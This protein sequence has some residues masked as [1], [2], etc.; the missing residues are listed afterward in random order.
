MSNSMGNVDQMS[1][2]L[3]SVAMSKV[4]AEGNIK[5]IYDIYINGADGEKNF[6]EQ[7]KGKV[8]LVV[9][10]TVGCGNA[11]QLQVLQWL[12]DT[13]G[14]EDFQIIGVPTNDYCGPGVTHGKWS[15]GITCGMDSQKYGEDVYG[16]TFKYTE[17]VS[18]NPNDLV[19]EST[20]KNGLGQEHGEPHDLYKEIARHMLNVQEKNIE[21]KIP[22]NEDYYSWWLNLGFD[23]GYTMGG[24]YEKYLVDKDGY[25]A[26]HYQC[27][28]LNYD[29]EKTVKDIAKKEGRLN[30]MSLG[31]G[32]S[33]KIFDE[34]YAVVK[35]HIEEL[36]NG[37]KSVINPS[38]QLSLV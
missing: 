2:F 22:R 11:N 19:S 20:G 28:I 23:G 31:M 15:Q 17:M 21:L 25:V 27:T 16:T 12:Q 33:R 1:A 32:R 18:S 4:K 29:H 13:Y 8:T 7:F 30:A 36:I 35:S 5:S 37:Q 26:K 10:T 24:N 6:M 3:D 34:E 14:G 38:Y 9:N